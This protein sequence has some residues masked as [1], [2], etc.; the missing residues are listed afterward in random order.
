MILVI[1]G[2]GASYDSVPTRPPVPGLSHI[3]RLPLADGL[4]SDRKLV[5]D[6]LSKFPD[7][8]PIVPYLQSA[9]VGDTIEHTLEIL[10]N[11]AKT[12]PVRKRLMAAIRFY[13]HFMIWKCDSKWNNEVELAGGITN[14]ITLLDQLRRSRQPDEPVC[15]VTFNYDRM[16][17]RALGSVGVAIETISQYIENDAFKLFKLHGSVHWAREV[18]TP[19]IDL[20]RNVWEVSRDLIQRAEQL[21]IS[22]RYR[23][24]QE[25][26]IGNL[27]MCHCSRRLRYRLR[28]KTST[29]VRMITWIVCGAISRKLPGCYWLAGAEQNNTSWAS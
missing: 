4:F 18:H 5:A 29:N 12:D 1:F 23:V 13:L 11:E 8:L 27:V 6:A 16:I 2:A 7:C 20:R 9:P 15:L 28:P 17:E 24:V 21:N 3:P 22:T 10:A 14:Y 19:G 26:P 25:D